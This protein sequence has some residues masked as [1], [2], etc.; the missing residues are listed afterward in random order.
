METYKNTALSPKERAKDLL[1]RLT[2]KEKVGQLNQHIYGFN[3]YIRTDSGIELSDEFKQ[4]AERWG[5]IGLLYGL[6]RADP[7]SKK[8]FSNGIHGKLAIEA[9]NKVQ[10]YTISHSRFGIPALICE[11]CPHGH[12]GLDGYLLP[13][14]LALGCTWNPELAKSAFSVCAKQLSEMHVDMALIS[15]LDILR[16]PRWG[17]SE[18]C[19]SEDPFLA[20]EFAKAVISGVTSESVDTVAKHC[21]AQGVT[22]GGINASSAPIGERE[23]REIHLPAVKAAVK[24]GCKGIMAAYN[25]IDGVLCHTN[26]WLLKTVLRTEFGFNGIVMA[27]G[28]AID[29]L[30]TIVDSSEEAAALALHSGIDVSLWDYAFTTLEKAVDK[31]LVDISE[32]DNAVLKVLTLKFERGLFENPYIKT[33]K[34]NTYTFKNHPQTLELARESAVLLK[35]S[36]SILPLKSTDTEI[37]VIGPLADDVYAMLGD[38]TP[39]Q[40]NGDTVTV[41]EGLQ[42]ISPKNVKIS[43][44]TDR[45]PVNEEEQ[46]LYIESAVSAAKKSQKIILVLGGSSSRF[47][48]FVFDNNGAVI[49]K[50]CNGSFVSLTDCGEGVDVAD[51]SLPKWQHKLLDALH[52]T[53]KSVITVIIAGRPYAVEAISKKSDALIYS[54]YPGP[55]GGTALAEILWGKVCPS[56][57]L[58]VSLP[59][60]SGQIP[61]FYNRKASYASRYSDSNALPIYPFGYGLNYADITLSNFNLSESCA[62]VN[63]IKQHG[64]TVSF[65]VKNNSNTKAFA[66]PQIY[67]R[68]KIASVV[69]RVKELKDFTKTELSP[70]ETIFIER[71]L[72]LDAFKICD[73]NMH[74]TAEPGEF[75]IYV[76]E[77]TKE[78]WKNT[79]KITDK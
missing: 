65:E 60:T 47:D 19:Y 45:L 23:L 36:N 75:E 20:S 11:E 3:S 8:D 73:I 30:N 25:E 70:N 56:G 32:I 68:D 22:T 59:N 57:R 78:H 17:R 50:N 64:I 16:D 31:K 63:D 24:A 21:C 12:Q 49:S 10:S 43:Y 39:S 28:R 41:L 79:F 1:Q 44:F 66:V 42:N 37:S 26:S 7:W 51:I 46:K 18:E 2:L 67:I 4:E 38:Y 72:T 5:G 58:S 62:T 33:D 27:D 71:K 55:A 13:V 53:G 69:P 15:M 77:G 34:L 52:G 74:Y 6:F 61:A 29:R 48:D 40:K 9:Y 35:N 14:N 54:F 76:Y